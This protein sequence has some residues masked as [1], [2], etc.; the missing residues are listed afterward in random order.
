LMDKLLLV[1]NEVSTEGNFVGSHNKLKSIITDS[2]VSIEKK[3][4]DILGSYPLVFNLIFT[5]NM[6][7]SILC[8]MY[9]RRYSFMEVSN[10]FLK[11]Y[12]YFD[13]LL[14]HCTQEVA[15]H[16]FTYIR[17]LPK[18]VDVRG[19]LDTQLK[20]DVQ[21][22][23]KNSVDLFSEIVVDCTQSTS[24][25]PECVRILSLQL[26][27]VYKHWCQETSDKTISQRQFGMKFK[28][29][30]GVMSRHTQHGREYTFVPT[31]EFNR[32]LNTLNPKPA[33]TLHP[34]GPPPARI[35]KSRPEAEYFRPSNE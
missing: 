35:L 11:N 4:I 15:D 21:Y 32:I 29:T 10:R 9:D 33:D 24:E 7:L 5:T 28:A 17:S 16:L 2:H 31:A 23:S 3:G 34:Q 20:R 12:E 1:C 6:A 26:Y 19:G 27:K 18:T 22:V 25:D 13:N 30:K 14:A 8:G